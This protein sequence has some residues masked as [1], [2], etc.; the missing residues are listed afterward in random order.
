MCG[1][2]IFVRQKWEDSKNGICPVLSIVPIF[3]IIC[4][5]GYLFSNDVPPFERR[6]N[7]LTPDRLVSRNGRGAKSAICS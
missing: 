3:F 1:R 7:N 5:R 6:E 2:G 4:F